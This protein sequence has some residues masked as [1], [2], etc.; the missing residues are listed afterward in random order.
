MDGLLFWYNDDGCIE[1]H[2]NI[3][4]LV[5]LEGILQAG[6][7]LLPETLECLTRNIL[8]ITFLSRSRLLHKRGTYQK[9]FY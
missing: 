9:G 2:L 3:Y 6:S 8:P 7:G 1:V 4:G 5:C